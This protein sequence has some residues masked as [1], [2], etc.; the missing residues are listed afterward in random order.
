MKRTVTF[1]GILEYDP[2]DYSTD[3][4]ERVDFA[5]THGD[6]HADYFLFHTG[7]VRVVDDHNSNPGE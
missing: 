4:E 3:P 5:L 1:T 7:E 2:A 6:K